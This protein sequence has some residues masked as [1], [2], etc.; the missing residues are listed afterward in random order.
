MES[1]AKENLKSVQDRPLSPFFIFSK[2]LR[3]DGKLVSAVSAAKQWK[4]LTKEERQNYID[5][6]HQ[7]RTLYDDYLKSIETGENILKAEKPPFKITKIRA[8]VGGIEDKK[9]MQ[10]YIPQ[11]LS[12]ILVIVK[13]RVGSVYARFWQRS[14]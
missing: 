2:K 5:Q 9:P 3:V 11:A 12:R 8:L 6:Y 13:V 1:K 7:A 10:P 14:Q 4:E